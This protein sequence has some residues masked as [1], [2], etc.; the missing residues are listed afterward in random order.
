MKKFVFEKNGKDNDLLIQWIIG[1]IK[2]H[3]GKRVITIVEEFPKYP[4]YKMLHRNHVSYM[5]AEIFDERQNG[6]NYILQFM[7]GPPNVIIASEDSIWM[8]VGSEIEFVSD[9]EFRIKNGEKEV[10]V[11]ALY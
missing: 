10:V 5:I 2:R 7:A 11:R 4:C 3:Y 6:V 8:S 9:D 1:F